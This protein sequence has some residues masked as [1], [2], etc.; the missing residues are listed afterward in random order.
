MMVSPEHVDNQTME[1]EPQSPQR[2][3]GVSKSK[4]IQCPY[5]GSY[6]PWQKISYQNPQTGE[7]KKESGLSQ[8]LSGC[9]VMIVGYVVVGFVVGL[10]IAGLLSLSGHL[11]DP[12]YADYGL[13]AIPFAFASAVAA[14]FVYRAWRQNWL[15]K[16]Y[17][18]VRHYTCWH[19]KN[20]WTVTQEPAARKLS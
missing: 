20:E 18:T 15:S 12:L 7:Q 3:Q 8:V 14:I 19:C 11:N 13:F 5:C 1:T 9:L 2:N 6:N 16:K 4:S 10:C 17:I